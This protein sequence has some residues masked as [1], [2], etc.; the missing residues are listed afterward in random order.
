MRKYVGD[1]W[2]TTVLNRNMQ[3][4]AVFKLGVFRPTAAI[5][6]FGTLANVA[7]LTG[8][9]PELKYAMKE[10]GKAGKNGKYG[11]L[12]DDLEVYEESANQASEFLD[13]SDYRRITV[14][15]VKLGKLFD[16]SMKG[17][18]KA[19][20]YTR[21]VAAIHA[22]EEYCKNIILILMIYILKPRR[23]SKSY[24]LC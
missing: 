3:A 13:S 20:A 5:A 11:Q 9:T 14:N 18:M 19:D 10:A 23:I 15:G 8:F 17:F 4:M 2:V 12:F 16:L 22:F 24:G 7:A 21:K 1:N 6:Q